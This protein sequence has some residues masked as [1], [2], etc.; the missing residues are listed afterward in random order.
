MDGSRPRLEE[1]HQFRE[2]MSIGEE[3]F[4][5]REEQGLIIGWGRRLPSA[6]ARRALLQLLHGAVQFLGGAVPRAAGKSA[7]TIQLFQHLGRSPIRFKVG[8]EAMQAEFRKARGTADE[9]K[10][11]DVGRESGR[12]E[13]IPGK[14][15]L[16][17][18]GER[19]R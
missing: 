1:C 8:I 11:R 19:F 7:E 16:H 18:I 10:R 3:A 5:P 12:T 4:S 13:M 9:K 6:A 15:R 14:G 2:A 17:Q